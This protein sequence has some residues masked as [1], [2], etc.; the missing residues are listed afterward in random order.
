M[1][2]SNA[3]TFCL[4]STYSFIHSKYTYGAITTGHTLCWMLAVQQDG[5][6]LDI[7]HDFLNFTIT[8]T[9]SILAPTCPGRAR[10]AFLAL[11]I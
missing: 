6:I 7:Q 2:F 3:L 9:V 11:G 5:Y 8:L 10:Q 1:Y 4:D